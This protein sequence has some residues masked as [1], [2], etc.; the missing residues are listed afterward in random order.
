MPTAMAW[1]TLVDALGSTYQDA[2]VLRAGTP[3]TF[4]GTLWALLGLDTNV[5]V[6]FREGCQ[7]RS[8]AGTWRVSSRP[9]LGCGS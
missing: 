3:G 7:V 2:L 9:T 4:T 6:C 5:S 8:R 1:A